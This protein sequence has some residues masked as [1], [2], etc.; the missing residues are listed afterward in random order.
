MIRDA[1]G[2]DAKLI[3]SGTGRT[4]ATYIVQLVQ[5]M[6]VPDKRLE[7]LNDRG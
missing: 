6:R 4:G 2:H 5:A 3:I 7:V 1:S